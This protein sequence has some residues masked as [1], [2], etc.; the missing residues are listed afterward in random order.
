M[1][2]KTSGGN[3]Q[4]K[5]DDYIKKI[6]YT[7]KNLYKYEVPIILKAFKMTILYFFNNTKEFEI[8]GLFS[9]KK[10]FKKESKNYVRYKDTTQI[11]PEHENL[12]CVVDKDLKDFLNERNNFKNSKHKE[13]LPDGHK[14]TFKF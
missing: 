6:L 10:R 1:A 7:N 13:F 11:I 5:K 12:K 3:T 14:R 2:K 8:K 9:F 4:T